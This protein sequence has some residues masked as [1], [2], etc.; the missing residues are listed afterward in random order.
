ML[1]PP[2]FHMVGPNIEAN[3]TNHLEVLKQKDEKIF[4]WLADAHEKRQKVIYLTIGSECYLVEWSIKAIKEGLIKLNQEKNVRA[5]W[6]FPKLG[7]Q[8]G[9]EHPFGE[10]DDRFIVSSWLPQIEI[11]NHPAVEAGMTHCGFGGTVEFLMC[12][13]P[14]L[15]FPHF[16]DQ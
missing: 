4:N 9:Y 10:D 2:N 15:T 13:V 11:L 8:P 12:G 16:G 1:L 7:E 14:M 5:I 6:Q 3:D